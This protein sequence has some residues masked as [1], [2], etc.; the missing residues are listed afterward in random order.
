[1][2]W[3]DHV[4]LGVHDLE[5]AGQRMLDQYGL[6]SVPGGRHPGWGTGN[7]IIPL[8][9]DYVELMAVLDRREA[10]ASFV[11]RSLLDRVADGDRLVGWC[12]G[13][14]DID[15]AAARLGLEVG[16]GSRVRPDGVVVRWRFVGAEVALK[17]RCLPFFISWE[18]PRDLH[19]SRAMV[20]HRVVPHGISWIEV[21]GSSSELR[22]WL[23]GEELP[24]RVV[25]G[26]EDLI[27]A[28]IATDAGE[29]TLLTATIKVR[30]QAPPRAA[31]RPVPD[32]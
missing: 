16:S 32:D 12:V 28:G 21:S 4:I 11:G 24:L 25:D 14:N 2:L 7:R 3:I 22:E 5:V 10:E 17:R 19:P 15:G 9:E 20:E 26:P 8:G 13:T 6:A 29:V 27:A 1:M 31:G 30:R 23:G 18:G